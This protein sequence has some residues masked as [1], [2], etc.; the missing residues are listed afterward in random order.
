MGFRSLSDYRLPPGLEMVDAFIS[1]PVNGELGLIAA[2]IHVGIVDAV[3]ERTFLRDN[4]KTWERQAYLWI[5]EDE[6][7]VVMSF[8]WC[9]EA[10]DLDPEP[11]R[12]FVLGAKK[13]KRTR[14]ITRNG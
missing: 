6:P 1:Q 5:F 14:R 8:R 13:V 11:I 2:V 12:K 7:N 4:V 3:S 9:C 10:L